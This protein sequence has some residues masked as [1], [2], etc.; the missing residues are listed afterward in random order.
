MKGNYE[1]IEK[2]YGIFKVINKINNNI[3]DVD[4]NKPFCSCLKWKYTRKN[5]KGIKKKCKHLIYCKGIKIECVILKIPKRIN[6]N[7]TDT[8]MPI[9]N[10]I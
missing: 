7:Y 6:Y 3:Y 5:K 10:R 1:I 8:D 4:I 9:M 2:G